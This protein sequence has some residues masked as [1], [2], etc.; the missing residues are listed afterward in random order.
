MRTLKK[1]ITGL[2]A[3]GLDDV[4]FTGCR[5][6]YQFAALAD[7]VSFLME[8]SQLLLTPNFISVVCDRSVT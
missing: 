1:A 5:F 8:I 3:V 7:F 6:N 4:G 2:R